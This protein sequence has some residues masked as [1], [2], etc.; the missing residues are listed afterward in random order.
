MT[1]AALLV[2]DA[3]GS[4]E[5]MHVRLIR[6]FRRGGDVGALG[7][8]AE[9]DHEVEEDGNGFAVFDGRRESGFANG[10]DGVLVE[11]KTDGA[12]NG[13]GRSASTRR[14]GLAI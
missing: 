2:L 13:T 9:F 10:I 1:T 12:R 14:L 5:G 4:R 8:D 11:A 6:S 3:V 7:V